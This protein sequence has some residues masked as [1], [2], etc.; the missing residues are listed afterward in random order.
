M[1]LVVTLLKEVGRRCGNKEVEWCGKME[2]LAK[3]I[4]RNQ[5]IL[6]NFLE[7]SNQDCWTH[8]RF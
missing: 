6:R 1:L 8:L 3:M 4:W 5:L 7:L 2:C